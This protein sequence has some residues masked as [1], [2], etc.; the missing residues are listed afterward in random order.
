MLL[1]NACPRFLL[2]LFF[3][4]ISMGPVIVPK[5]VLCKIVF[6]YVKQTRF[7]GLIS[8]VLMSMTATET[9]SFFL[10]Q[11]VNAFADRFTLSIAHQKS[12]GRVSRDS[13]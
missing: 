8:Q 9:I 5:L 2:N 4:S 12:S 11:R 1:K 6:L 3:K 10:N 13:K 7:I